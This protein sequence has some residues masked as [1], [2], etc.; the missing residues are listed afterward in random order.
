[1]YLFVT[2]ETNLE[3]SEDAQFFI[4]GGLA[5]PAETLAQFHKEIRKIRYDAGYKSED[6]LKFDTRVRPEHV[7]AKKATEAKNRVVDLCLVLQAKLIIYAI[8]H[9]IARDQTQQVRVTFGINSVLKSFH[10][11]L[12]QE[13]DYGMFV[14][15][16]LPIE[17]PV[18]YLVEKFTSG[19]KYKEK[20]VPLS[21]IQLYAQTSINLSH[22]A[23]A[24][25]I[26]LGSFRYCINNPKNED[27]AGI[28]MKK[29]VQ[30]MWGEKRGN[31][32]NPFERGFILRP[33][34]KSR[35]GKYVAI[36]NELVDHI[37]RL[38]I[39]E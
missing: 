32:S 17:S 16:S 12:E 34:E 8:H 36:Y 14:A 28:M 31:S 26:V 35:N 10:D 2:D 38:L 23:S 4:Y 39:K 1:M 25:D 33:M 9:G 30:M 24:T 21:R 11:F 20:L 29:V 7:T 6:K 19:L 22:I 27:A 18:Q 3:P 37:N 13:K 15:D 5:F